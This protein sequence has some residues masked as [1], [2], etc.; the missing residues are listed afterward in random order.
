[1][2]AHNFG[3][4]LTRLVLVKVSKKCDQSTWFRF[5]QWAHDL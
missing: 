3:C 5:F 2:A 1:M 4:C